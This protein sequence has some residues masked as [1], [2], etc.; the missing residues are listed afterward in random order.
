MLPSFKNSMCRKCT[1][2]YFFTKML[3]MLV[4]VTMV[5]PMAPSLSTVAEPAELCG[6]SGERRAREA[7]IGRWEECVQRQ[8][9][10]GFVLVNFFCYSV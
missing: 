4:S 9:H 1:W 6:E 2:S 8:R 10:R 7:G 5:R 3:R